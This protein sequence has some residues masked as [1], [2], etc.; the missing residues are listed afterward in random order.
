MAGPSAPGTSVRGAV[1]YQPSVRPDTLRTASRHHSPPAP[2]GDP[3]GGS[4]SAAANARAALSGRGRGSAESP[5]GPTPALRGAAG[6]G[7]GAPTPALRGVTS[8]SPGR[9]GTPG[10]SG[11]L[12]GP[13][14][15]VSGR[16]AA[17]SATAA[18]R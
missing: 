11:R 9:T 14:V 17:C 1:S 10:V 6:V 3:G 18:A 8:T 15:T 5:R 2:A 16:L 12:S 7:G 13:D 4:V